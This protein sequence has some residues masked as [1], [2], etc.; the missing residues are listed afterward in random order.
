MRPNA[1]PGQALLRSSSTLS[2]CPGRRNDGGGKAGSAAAPWTGRAGI[3]RRNRAPWGIVD[4]EDVDRRPPCRQYLPQVVPGHQPGDRAG[5]RS[6]PARRPARREPRCGGG[7]RRLRGVALHA[8]DRAG[9]ADARVRRPASRPAQGD[10]PPDDPG[11]GQAADREPRRGRV[12][13][14]RV[15]VLRRAGAR[16][17]GEG[18]LPGVPQ[19]DQL[20]AQGAVRGGGRHRPVELSASG[21]RR[22]HWRP[23]TR[24]SS[25]RR[26]RRRCRP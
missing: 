7:G 2:Q 14:R 21:R 5:H 6:H 1:M 20:R 24:S 17:G 16:S 22:P 18:D 12:V 26:K 8:R 9:G 11:G 25:S 4:A 13:R 23:A 19:S 10:R 3:M 15:R